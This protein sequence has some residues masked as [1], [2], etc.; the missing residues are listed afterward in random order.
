M[1]GVMLYFLKLLHYYLHHMIMS[2]L[3]NPT[4][5]HTLAPSQVYGGLLI[6]ICKLTETDGRHIK[7]AVKE[8]FRS[9]K[10]GF[11]SRMN[12]VPEKILIAVW[13]K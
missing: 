3:C 10:R 6:L 5:Y 8:F 12:H 4:Y 7:W 11:L 9:K 13:T 1:S 2:S